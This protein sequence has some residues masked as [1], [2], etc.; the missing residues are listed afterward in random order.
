MF[1]NAIGILEGEK[2]SALLEIENVGTKPVNF[3]QIVFDEKFPEVSYEEDFY[4]CESSPPPS[5]AE[6]RSSFP[7]TLAQN[8]LLTCEESKI[9]LPLMPFESV[10]VP[11]QIVGKYQSSGGTLRIKYGFLQP[12]R[13]DP[14]NFIRC[15][16]FPI[17]LAVARP[18]T[19]FNSNIGLFQDLARL[20][21]LSGIPNH[22]LPTQPSTP[23][24]DQPMVPKDYFFVSFNVQ[25]SW[26]TSF[27]L[28][29]TANEAEEGNPLKVVNSRIDKGCGQRVVVCLRRFT[30]DDSLVKQALPNIRNKQFVITQE[31]Q[32]LDKEVRVILNHLFSKLLTHAFPFFFFLSFPPD[33]LVQEGH[34]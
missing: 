32:T 12:Q 1:S 8:P 30:L 24:D 27:D 18:L 13:N 26:P 25:N 19:F 23:L 9:K 16:E 11:I 4:Y 29:F 6:P 22:H 20:E 7:T 10:F 15:I 33:L 21:N 2:F 5:S 28:K 17:S 14:F 31:S 34:H 3:V